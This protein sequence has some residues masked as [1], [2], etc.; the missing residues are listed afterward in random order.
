MSDQY[1]RLAEELAA[2]VVREVCEPHNPTQHNE[3]VSIILS[4]VPLASLLRDKEV[5]DWLE[6]SSAITIE[7]SGKKFIDPVNLREL[8][9]AA[10]KENKPK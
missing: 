4:T 9:I 1:D 5:I 6:K 7:H 8:F 10:T 3:F 2:G